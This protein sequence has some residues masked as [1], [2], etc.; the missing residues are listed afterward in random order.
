MADG[1]DEIFEAINAGD[2]GRIKALLEEEPALAAARDASGV[3]AIMQA[4]YRRHTEIV[5][6]LLAAGPELD[7]FESVSLGR[8][9]AVRAMLDENAARATSWSADG[10]TALHLAAFF[11]GEE[12]ARLLIDRGA[13]VNAVA[14]NGMAVAPLHSAVASGARGIIT[15]LLERHADPN[16]RQH[17]GWTALHAAA[18]HG[19]QEWIDLLLSHGADPRAAS[20]DGKSAVEMAKD[21][22]WQ[23]LAERLQTYGSGK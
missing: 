14:R 16:A 15:L 20:D 6:A 7:L 3:S 13:D 23:E 12:S 18:K 1:K 17:G 10:F 9:E 8:T 5:D 11:N 19:K 2:A 22:G 21:A 4:L